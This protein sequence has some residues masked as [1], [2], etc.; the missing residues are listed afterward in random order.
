MLLVL[1]LS[2]AQLRLGG[3]LRRTLAI[4]TRSLGDNFAAN[5]ISLFKTF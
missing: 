2:A 1:V 5:S 3:A 4:A